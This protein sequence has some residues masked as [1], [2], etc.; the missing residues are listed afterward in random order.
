MLNILEEELKSLK[1]KYNTKR[2]TKIIKNIN[3][4]DE[5]K[6]INQRI[7][8]ELIN[9]KGKISIDNKFNIKNLLINNY[10]KL[11]ENDNKLITK[12]NIYRFICNFNNNLNL[13][14]LTYSGK[15]INID[16]KRYLNTDYK[17][18]SKLLSNIN[19][20]EII[21]FHNFNGITDNYLCILC[22]DGRFNT[23]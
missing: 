6:F 5:N 15:V 23:S 19:P 1:D 3:I 2:S 22:K 14:A 20:Y 7:L 4:D 8:N 10:K 18:D 13:F 17:L 11:I 9:N 16:W 12:K 21:N